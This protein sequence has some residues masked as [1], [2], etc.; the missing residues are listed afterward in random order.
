MGQAGGTH[1]ITS[2][3]ALRR[4]TDPSSL[5][6]RSWNGALRVGGVPERGKW[7]RTRQAF[8]GLGLPSKLILDEMGVMRK[9]VKVY[10]AE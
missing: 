2:C 3:S 10:G 7:A 5:A 4:K 8:L 9:E 1:G 6:L